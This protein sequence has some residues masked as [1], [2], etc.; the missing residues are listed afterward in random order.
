VSAQQGNRAKNY[1]GRLH[2]AVPVRPPD[3]RRRRRLPP[4]I[5][6]I[7]QFTQASTGMNTVWGFPA[8]PFSRW[9]V[10]YSYQRVQVKDLN[11]L[12]KTSAATVNNPF[13]SD[14]LL[15]AEGGQRR[16]SKIGPSYQYNSIDNPIFPTTGGSWRCRP[17]SRASGATRSSTTRAAKALPT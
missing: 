13:L 15:L 14:S 6:Y 10:S 5:Q 7:G 1:S 3:H 17:S 4:E 9:F 16:I 11:P 12:Y 2:R 8:G